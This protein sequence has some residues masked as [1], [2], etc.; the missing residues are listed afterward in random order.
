VPTSHWGG[1]LTGDE[2][3]VDFD[4]PCRC[5]ATTQHIG[6]NIQRLSS[7]QGGDDKIMG[8]ATPQVYEDAMKVLSAR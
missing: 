4:S 3:D 1:I 8:A 5:G 6:M 2:V 7:G